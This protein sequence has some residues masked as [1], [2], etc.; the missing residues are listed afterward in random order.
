MIRFVLATALL[1]V[2]QGLLASD[3]AAEVVYTQGGAIYVANLDGRILYKTVTPWDVEAIAASLKQPDIVFQRSIGNSE[4]GP[5]Y[6]LHRRT[7]RTARLTRGPYWAMLGSAGEEVYGEPDIS[8]QGDAIVFSVRRPGPGPHRDLSEL[9]GPLA[10]MN[11]ATGKTQLLSKTLDFDGVGPAYANRPVWSPDGATILVS[12][13]EG[14]AILS[15]DGRSLEPIRLGQ[16][17]GSWT[18]ALGWAGNRCVFVGVGEGGRVDEISILHL[19]SK[20]IEPLPLQSKMWASSAHVTRMQ[21]AG[22]WLLIESQKESRLYDWSTFALR[23]AFPRGA[24]LSRSFMDRFVFGPDGIG[25][26][27]E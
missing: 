17:E 12:F 14:F 19:E 5:L 2:R 26:G 1:L 22:P 11:L 7:G 15:R 27:C 20:Q 23:R 6:R 3:P 25:R 4:G 8:P 16:W 13:E 10:V 24:R 21:L 18:T 9:A